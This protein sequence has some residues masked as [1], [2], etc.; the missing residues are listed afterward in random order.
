MT[1]T[2]T[3][4]H[5]TAIAIDGRGVLITGAPGAGKTALALALIGRA[6]AGGYP[7]GLVADDRVLLDADAD[8]VTV[9]C[10]PAIA[11]KVELRGWGVVEAPEIVA[12]PIRIALLVRLVP[13]AEA[14]RFAMDHTEQL[15]G[16]DLP[17]LRLPA[18][19]APTAPTAVLA[20]LGLP[21]WL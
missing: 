8:G 9:R 10:P 14:L 20:A 6:R 12:G 11:G 3:P 5:G 1:T 4:P 21:I 18:G 19:P 17:A 2:E 7:A 15:I 16:R 13:P